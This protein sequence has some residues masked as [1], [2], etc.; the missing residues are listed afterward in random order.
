MQGGLM[1][2]FEQETNTRTHTHKVKRKTSH[3]L[4]FVNKGI[5]RLKRNCILFIFCL[6]IL[7]W[8]SSRKNPKLLC[9]LVFLHLKRARAQKK[10]K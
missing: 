4:Q 6:L 10:N 8:S 5:T 2:A 1:D 7:D 3:P 9:E